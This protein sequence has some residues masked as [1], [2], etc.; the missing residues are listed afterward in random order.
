V[1]SIFTQDWRYRHNR[2]YPLSSR[3]IQLK[4]QCQTIVY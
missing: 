2:I 3:N 4:P 1:Y